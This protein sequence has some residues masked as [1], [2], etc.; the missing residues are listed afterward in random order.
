[1]YH[2]PLISRRQYSAV[3]HTMDV[4]RPQKTALIIYDSAKTRRLLRHNRASG[5]IAPRNRPLIAAP[6]IIMMLHETHSSRIYRTHKARIY[7]LRIPTI[8]L[9]IRPFVR[10]D[11]PRVYNSSRIYSFRVQFCSRQ[12]PISVTERRYPVISF[13]GEENEGSKRDKGIRLGIKRE[14]VGSASQENENGS[15]W[16]MNRGRKK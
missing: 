1:M 8:V 7:S 2:T 3:A 10:P 5:K 14:K 4:V 11:T 16:Q 15:K 12:M 13:E 9:Q 6:S